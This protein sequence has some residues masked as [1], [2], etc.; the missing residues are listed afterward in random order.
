MAV[1]PGSTSQLKMVFSLDNSK[2]HTL[3]IKDPKQNLTLSEVTDVAETMLSKEA[4]IVGGSPIAALSDSYIQT[5]T[6]TALA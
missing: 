2:T 1:T 6:I 5:T 3:S 4:I